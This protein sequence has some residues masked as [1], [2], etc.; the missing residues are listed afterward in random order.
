[1]RALVGV[2]HALGH[3]RAGF[4]LV[5]LDPQPEHAALGEARAAAFPALVVADV[6]IAVRPEGQAH[7][8]GDAGLGQGRNLDPL[9]HLVV[10]ADLDQAGLLGRVGKVGTGHHQVAV[11]GDFHAVRRDAEF[12]QADEEFRGLQGGSL[13]RGV[14]GVTGPERKE[15][16]Q[17]QGKQRLFGKATCSFPSAVV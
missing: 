15:P 2:F 13:G 1:M 10:L 14:G 3:H 4:Q 8:A 11:R 5:V 17:G 6:N 7:R 16:S 9:P 12:R